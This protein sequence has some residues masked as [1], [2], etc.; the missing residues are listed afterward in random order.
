MTLEDILDFRRVLDTVRSVGLVR[1]L[2]FATPV[3]PTLWQDGITA[4]SDHGVYH[5]PSHLFRIRDDN[6]PEAA[7]RSELSPPKLMN[8]AYM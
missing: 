8:L 6:G 4:R 2:L 3:W 5:T 7:I 1:I